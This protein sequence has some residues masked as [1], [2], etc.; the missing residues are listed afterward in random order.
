M[1]ADALSR[2]GYGTDQ[3]IQA[4]KRRILIR[5]KPSISPEPEVMQVDETEPKWA[6]E[7]IGYLKYRELPKDKTQAQKLKL[8]SARYAV[9]GGVLYR[10]GYTLPLLKCLSATET[11]YVLSEIHKGV[12]GNH[13]GG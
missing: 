8:Q 1:C 6:A 3:E 2:V 5:A 12:C 13:S 7:I 11:E 9:I 10:R 4:A